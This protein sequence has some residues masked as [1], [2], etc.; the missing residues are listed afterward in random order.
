MNKGTEDPGMARRGLCPQRG[1]R[2]MGNSHD[3]MFH[4]GK[5]NGEKYSRTV[6]GEWVGLKPGDLI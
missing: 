4:S 3:R 5:C 1:P 6:A 2:L